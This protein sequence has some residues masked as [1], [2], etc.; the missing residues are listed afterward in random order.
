MD[1]VLVA[2]HHVGC[3]CCWCRILRFGWFVYRDLSSTR[4][5]SSMISKF[6]AELG[7]NLKLKQL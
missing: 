2:G 3:R 7:G 5:N 4:L 1:L 6:F